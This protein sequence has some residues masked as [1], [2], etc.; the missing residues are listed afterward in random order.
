MGGRGASSGISQKTTFKHLFHGSPAVN[1]EEFDVSLSGKN[2]GTVEGLIYFTDDYNVADEFSWERLESDSMLFN[3][4]GQ[5]G[6][7]YETEITMNH[8][9]DFRNLTARDK[10][11]ILEIAHKN[12]ADYLTIEQIGKRSSTNHQLLKTEIGNLAEL[13]KYGYD[14]IIAKMYRDKPALEYG[15]FD[16]KKIKIK[17]K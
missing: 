15:V 13:Q 8:P 10:K 3:Q 14:G 11:V 6:K 16:K 4:K 9:L 12:G 1:I 2:T 7:V 5:K 17:K